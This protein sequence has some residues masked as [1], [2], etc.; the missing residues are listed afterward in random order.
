[1]LKFIR[2]ENTRLKSQ[3]LLSTAADLFDPSDPLMRRAHRSAYKLM[4][5]EK[6]QEISS[7]AAEIKSLTKEISQT[8]AAA[9]VIDLSRIQS[10]GKGWSSRRFNP[11]QQEN[12]RESMFAS[13]AGRVVESGARVRALSGKYVIGSTRSGG[14]KVFT[15]LLIF[16]EEE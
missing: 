1:M 12:A 14:Q 5:P 11:E 10:N 16:V 13:L 7:T 6:E 8:F 4:Q 3:K 15:A 2:A 9:E